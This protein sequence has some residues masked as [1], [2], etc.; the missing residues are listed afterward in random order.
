[1][2]LGIPQHPLVRRAPASDLYE[3]ILRVVELLKT[4]LMRGATASE[5]PSAILRAYQLVT[6]GG[7]WHH[8]KLQRFRYYVFPAEWTLAQDSR[9]GA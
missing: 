9:G 4:V 3:E 8:F 1:M 5:M 7:D 2:M 6:P